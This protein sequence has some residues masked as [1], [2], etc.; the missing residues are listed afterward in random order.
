MP[1]DKEKKK[2][3]S[4]N[5]ESEPRQAYRKD[6]GE[7]ATMLNEIIGKTF[8]RP[9]KFKTAVEMQKKII[10]FFVWC[11]ENHQPPTISG[12]VIFLGYAD[13][14]S[15]Y[16]LEKQAK[17]SY[18]IKKARTMIQT[19]YER[20]LH[21]TT[22]TGSIFAL[23]NFGWDDKSIIE[24]EGAVPTTIVKNYEKKSDEK[25]FIED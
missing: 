11:K 15:F 4:N 18:T 6:P 17:F 16:D 8:G 20:N 3:Q 10:E 7:G 12:L 21:G 5:P 23:K 19:V 2:D 13:R 9:P 22:P 25:K 14:Q 24:H 1:K